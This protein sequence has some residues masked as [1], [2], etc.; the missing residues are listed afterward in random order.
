ME[1]TWKNTSTRYGAVTKFFHWAV[2]LLFINQY[3]VAKLMMGIKQNEFALGFSQGTLYNW[4]KS[5]GLI[6]LAVVLFRY[7]WRRTNRLPDWDATLS[8]AEKKAIHWIER[9]LYICMFV[10]PI[11]G[12][13]FVMAGGFGV[14]FFSQW[15]LPDPIGRHEWL[16]GLAQLTHRATGW[17][18][19]LALTSHLVLGIRHH[20]LHKKRYLHRMLPVTQQ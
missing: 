2:F 7:T 11:S 12:Y 1:R 20:L 18:I 19:L 13:L 15:H 16:A 6:I 4:H 10:M 5:I 8:K 3:V 14:H 17:V 9:V